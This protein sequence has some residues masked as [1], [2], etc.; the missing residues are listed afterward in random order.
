MRKNKDTFLIVRLST[1][2]KNALAV[3]ASLA[4]RKMSDYIRTTIFNPKSA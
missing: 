1:D 4:G 2:E 3:L